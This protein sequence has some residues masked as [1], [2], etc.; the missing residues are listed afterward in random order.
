MMVRFGNL[1]V[2]EFEKRIGIKLSKEDR[3]WFESHRQNNATVKALDKLH[4]F[5]MPFGV[6]CGGDIVHEAAKR[7]TAYGS[8]N[9][10]ERLVIYG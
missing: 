4:I 9:F 10:K 3:A 8:E 2:K 6:H 5:D 1:S 7:L